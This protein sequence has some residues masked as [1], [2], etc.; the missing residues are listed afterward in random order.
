MNEAPKPRLPLVSRLLPGFLAWLSIRAVH[1]AYLGDQDAEY[2]VASEAGFGPALWGAELLFAFLGLGAAVGMW[3][4]WRHTVPLALTALAFYASIA[5]FQLW[6][7]ELDPGL[8]RRAYV[9]SREAR[10]LPVFEDQVDFMF[11]GPGRTMTWIVGATFSLA[12]LAV[13][14]RRR[15]DFEPLEADDSEASS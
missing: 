3:L 13:L 11:S 12:P 9:A 5:G 7:M 15:A 8:A 1:L 6:Q 10:G 14:L 2:R 4:R